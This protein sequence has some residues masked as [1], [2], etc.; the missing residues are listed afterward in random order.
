MA[1]PHPAPWPWSTPGPSLKRCSVDPYLVSHPEHALPPSYSFWELLQPVW[2]EQLMNAREEHGCL[3][4]C[5]PEVCIV[6][7]TQFH[8]LEFVTDYAP[9]IYIRFFI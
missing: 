4:D 9:A 1:T 6:K 7:F 5:S 3:C 2:V 8:E